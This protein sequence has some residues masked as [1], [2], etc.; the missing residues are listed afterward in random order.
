MNNWMSRVVMLALWAFSVW[1]WASPPY[2]STQLQVHFEA[3][4]DGTYTIKRFS[5]FK[6]DRPQDIEGL[7]RSITSFDG[8]L[9]TVK[10]VEAYTLTPTGQRIDVQPEAIKTQSDA[11]NGSGFSSSMETIIVFP[12]VGVNGQVCYRS[13]RV[14]HTPIFAGRFSFQYRL[15]P[16]E[17]MEQAT[18]DV[19]LHDSRAVVEMRKLSG[20]LV[21]QQDGVRHY[22]YT[23]AIAE[24]MDPDPGDPPRSV[25]DPG[26]WIS[27]YADYAALARAYHEGA[28][29]MAAVTPEIQALAEQITQGKTGTRA[30]VKAVYE[31]VVKNIRYVAIMV[32]RGGW[33][34][35]SAAA[36][37]QHRY[38][39]CKDK[40][41][42]LE[43]LLRAK[44]I[45]STAVLIQVDP[46]YTIPMPPQEGAFDHVITYVP[47]LDLYLDGTESFTPLG[48]VRKWLADKPLLHVRT[49]EVRRGPVSSYRINHV[50]V[51][52]VLTMQSDGHFTGRTRMSKRGWFEP[53]SREVQFE[54][55]AEP[56]ERVINE[57]LA[58]AN[59]TG[60]GTIK[61]PDP[62]D[63]GV[64]WEVLSEY[65]L[66]PISNVPGPGAFAL[67]VGVAPG[68]LLRRALIKPTTQKR[69]SGYR[70]FPETLR[71]RYTI[72]FPNNIR[73]TRIPAAVLFSE[74]QLRYRAQYRLRQGVLSVDR[75]FEN[76]SGTIHCKAEDY[77][78]WR[79][80][81]KVL[82]RD[83]RG[84]VF[85]E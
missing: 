39:D 62:E 78:I 17:V 66:D 69:R 84:Q 31:W 52:T 54:N 49:G 58:V 53:S 70:C 42:L 56:M 27:N 19:V 36:V 57:V 82:Q 10:I 67:P 77:E 20:G 81:H 32:G 61:T 46:V 29:P 79:R 60:V 37:L 8:N 51:Q 13:E 68:E 16:Y 24:R 34:P 3:R 50:D 65:I 12:E 1:A 63:L 38:G 22:R 71:E 41:I 76:R 14:R 43:A 48:V 4:A 30:Q 25:F 45:E 11:D 18:L 83:L 59:E 64:P 85:Y 6:A 7:S 33:V 21:A 5:C 73:I 40:S 23:H 75:R 9:E 80:F 72:R 47:E 35:H 28:A 74:G 15:Y 26:V 55:K 44:G 2:H